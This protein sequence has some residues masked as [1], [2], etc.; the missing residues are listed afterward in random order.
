VIPKGEWKIEEKSKAQKRD[1]SQKSWRQRYDNGNPE[2]F[3][4][5]CVQLQGM[6]KY[7]IND[8]RG[9]PFLL[10]LCKSKKKMQEIKRLSGFFSRNLDAKKSFDER[11]RRFKLA[12]KETLDVT[13]L[14]WEDRME[15]S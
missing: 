5:N 9:S 11:Q 4:K 2:T 10:Q 13:W 1:E 3:K 15:K 8:T 12:G 6:I 7:L 14:N